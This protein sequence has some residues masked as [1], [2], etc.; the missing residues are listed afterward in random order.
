[1]VVS[2]GPWSARDLNT[3]RLGAIRFLRENNLSIVVQSAGKYLAGLNSSYKRATNLFVVL[4]VTKLALAQIGVKINTAF[5]SLL[6]TELR[7][8]ELPHDW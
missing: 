5:N 2:V 4:T 3:F 7:K 1:M 6:R 8:G